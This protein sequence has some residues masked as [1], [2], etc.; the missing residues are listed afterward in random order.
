MLD[1]ENNSCVGLVGVTVHSIQM[2]APP[3]PGD[4]GGSSGAGFPG[5]HCPSQGESPALRVLSRIG[6]A[7]RLTMAR[8]SFPTHDRAKAVRTQEKPYLGFGFWPFP[9]LAVLGRIPSDA[10]QESAADNPAP[11]QPPVCHLLSRSQEL[12]S[13]LLG[14]AVCEVVLL[15]CRFTEHLS[16]LGWAGCRLWGRLRVLCPLGAQF[17]ICFFLLGFASSVVCSNGNIKTNHL[18]L[19]TCELR[20]G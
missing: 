3:L 8:H 6:G 17:L 10:G 7:A 12:Y 18:A 5:A 9:R 2:P 11:T 13:T 19:G 15:N 20:L 1:S 16:G 4:A 14:C